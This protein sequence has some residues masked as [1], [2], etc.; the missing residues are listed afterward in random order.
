MYF[1]YIS[2]NVL[3]KPVS[4]FHWLSNPG[5]KTSNEYI[6]RIL[7]IVQLNYQHRSLT[8]LHLILVIHGLTF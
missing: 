5:H 6:C 3:Y 1:G 8:V 2:G 4:R 7:G